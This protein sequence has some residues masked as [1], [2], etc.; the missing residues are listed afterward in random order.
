MF[1]NVG[2]LLK[3][4]YA[5]ISKKIERFS[6]RVL[7]IFSESVKCIFVLFSACEDTP[8]A[9]ELVAEVGSSSMLLTVSS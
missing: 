2:V 9:L 1:R 4:L 6:R 7:Y 3:G 5:V 8:L